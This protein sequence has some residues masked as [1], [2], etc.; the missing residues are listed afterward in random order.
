[1]LAAI[2]FFARLVVSAALVLSAIWKTRHREEFIRAVR[3]LAPKAFRPVARPVLVA[4]VALELF[5]SGALLLGGTLPVPVW[6][7]PAA[8]ISLFAIFS[9][10]LATAPSLESCGCWTMPD[11]QDPN[12]ARIL[13][14][15]RNVFLAGF[16]AV[17]LAGPSGP[18]IDFL[19]LI[20]GGIAFGLLAVELPQILATARAALASSSLQ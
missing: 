18:S 20:P 4:V 9:L 17:A 2:A 5:A 3:A 16:S 7:G 11:V 6:L 12:Q 13:L 1:M 19:F 14:V 8:A 10:L 15:L